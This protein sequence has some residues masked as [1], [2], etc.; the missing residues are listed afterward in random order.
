MSYNITCVTSQMYSRIDVVVILSKV[1]I[2]FSLF[3][4]FFKNYMM[5][6]KILML[7]LQFIS[8]KFNY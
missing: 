5:V 6:H 8:L 2:S 3:I 7:T 4:Q 1:K